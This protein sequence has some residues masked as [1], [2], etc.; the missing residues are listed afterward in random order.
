MS[1]RTRIQKTTDITRESWVNDGA[2]LYRR[3]VIIA[4]ILTAFL[5]A[6]P[7]VQAFEGDIHPE[8][9]R[10]GLGSTPNDSFLRTAVR[11]NINHQHAWMDDKFPSGRGGDDEKHFDDCEFNG[12]AE[13]IRDQYRVA[14]NGLTAGRPWV[15]TVMFGNIL[16]TV[17][18]FYSHSNWV[19]LGFPLTK[20]NP[21]TVAVEVSQ[22]DLVD[23]SGA[24]SNLAQHWFAP[25]G[26]AMVRGDILLGGDD[27]A[28]IPTGWSIQRNG[29]GRFIPTL[30]DA[31]GRTRGRLLETGMGFQDGECSVGIAG[32]PFALAYT[33]IQHDN[34]NKDCPPRRPLTIFDSSGCGASDVPFVE[35]QNKHAKARALA[36]LQTGYEWCRLV[37]EA[38]WSTVTACY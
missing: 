8:I 15:T 5:G 12:A 24:Q 2:P 26:G 7:S 1:T 25:S 33:G 21:A 31:Q 34:L 10:E 3:L 23:L 16:H 28:S 13:F 38:D 37:R 4:L 19:E 9:T 14:Q 11:R 32:R 17:Q 20:D 30:V 35:R 6:T 29:A 22:S 27:W 18:D 36:T